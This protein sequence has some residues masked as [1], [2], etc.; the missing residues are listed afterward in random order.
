MNGFISGI[1]CT[2]VFPGTQIRILLE[3]PITYASKAYKLTKKKKKKEKEKKA[4]H[5]NFF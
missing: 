5:A 4:L 1:P 2:W 3:G